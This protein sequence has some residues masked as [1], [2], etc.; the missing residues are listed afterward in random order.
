MDIQQTIFAN[1]DANHQIGPYK[2]GQVVGEGGVSVVVSADSIYSKTPVVLKLLPKSHDKRF[3]I[4]FE[5]E[6]EVITQLT[7]LNI[8]RVF[9]FGESEYVVYMAMEYI[10]GITLHNVLQQESRRIDIDIAIKLV[11]QIACALDYIHRRGFV[12][13]D[14]KPSNILVDNHTRALLLDFG[15]VLDLSEP[16]Q[17]HETGIYGT[18]TYISP[19]Q[20]QGFMDIDGRSDLYSLGVILYEMLTGRRPF[21]GSRNQLLHAH[22]KENPPAPSKFVYMSP[23]LE[24]IL[25]KA[26]A[27]NPKE[28]FQTGSEL[29]DALANVEITQ[30]SWFQDLQKSLQRMVNLV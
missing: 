8:V 13:R 9:D 27:K 3:H 19:E 24:G 17:R 12:H 29:N 26:I 14:V 21:Y 18:S 5:R 22:I 30:P 10:D 11:C 16:K 2:L 6:Y 7:H 20:A 15:T 23:E 4:A 28:R 1:L 25:Q